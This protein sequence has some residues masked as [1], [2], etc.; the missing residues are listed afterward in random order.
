MNWVFHLSLWATV[1]SLNYKNREDVQ[2]L[3]VQGE[4]RSDF[5]SQG[6]E[7]N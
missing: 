6:S 4:V 5:F 2:E 1:L 7:K 3:D